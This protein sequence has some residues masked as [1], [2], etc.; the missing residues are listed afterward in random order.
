MST[1]FSESKLLPVNETGRGLNNASIMEII[2]KNCSIVKKMIL[3]LQQNKGDAQAELS[4]LLHQIWPKSFSELSTTSKVAI[5]KKLIV[6]SSI[7]SILPKV[8]VDEESQ[9]FS[10]VYGV[11]PLSF[12]EDL[13]DNARVALELIKLVDSIKL[14]VQKRGRGRGATCDVKYGAN[15]VSVLNTSKCN[16]TLIEAA[17]FDQI[18]Q[19]IS[20]I[21]EFAE[22]RLEAINLAQMKIEHQMLFVLGGGE[23]SGVADE[24]DR[25]NNASHGGEADEETKETNDVSDNNVN[26]GADNSR[27]II[28]DDVIIYV[29]GTIDN[30]ITTE[31]ITT[32]R[33]N[34]NDRV[35]V[36]DDIDL[37][38][39]II[40]RYCIWIFYN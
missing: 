29:V 6:A 22:I 16:G 14:L 37:Y 9:V 19:L 35:I 38:S 36:V 15:V 7:I 8:E 32:M 34:S 33:S 11:T 23:G 2:D 4:N 24:D 21:E 27:G 20:M 5:F 10:A 3:D 17:N 25:T 30:D 26:G 40:M 13:E 39:R 12:S 31:M 28:W 1:T 18:E